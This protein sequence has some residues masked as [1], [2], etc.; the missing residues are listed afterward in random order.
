MAQPLLIS[1]AGLPETSSY[2][3][4]AMALNTYHSGKFWELLRKEKM[5]PP[6]NPDGSLLFSADLYRRLFNTARVPGETKDE[7]HKYFK[8]ESEGSCPA[9]ALVVSRGR[10]FYFDFVDENGDVISPLDFLYVYRI[11][12][13]K[14]ENEVTEKGERKKRNSPQHVVKFFC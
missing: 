8:T 14:V 5:R 9:V 12:R 2:R 11:I 10:V 6:S 3:L 4:K 13:D 7:I 1:T